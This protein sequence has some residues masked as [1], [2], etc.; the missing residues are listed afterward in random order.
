MSPEH[1]SVS[2]ESSISS[3]TG[4]SWRVTD[5]TV[6]NQ[7]T[8]SSCSGAKA[9]SEK[10]EYLKGAKTCSS[11]TLNNTLFSAVF[12]QLSVGVLLIDATTYQLVEVN[13]TLAAWL[14]YSKEKL[15]RLTFSSLTDLSQEQ[16]KEL[17]ETTIF[18]GQH[19]ESCL[20]FRC[21]DESC[22][23]LEGQ[24]Q[25]IVH[26]DQM[27]ICWLVNRI[28]QQNQ[29]VEETNAWQQLNKDHT[30]NVIALHQA[31][32]FQAAQK[33][34]EALEH[35]N[36]LKDNFLST[37]SHEL[38]TPIATI[39]MAIQ[40]LTLALGQE[41]LLHNPGKA[42]GNKTKIAHYLKILNDE[43]NR[44]IALITDL[45]DLQRLE[46]GTHSINVQLISLKPYLE[47]IVRPFQEQAQIHDQT[48]QL[49]IPETLPS[50]ISD[51]QS[52]ERIL[53]ELLTNACKYSPCGSRIVLKAFPAEDSTGLQTL[54]FRVC[55]SGVEIPPEQLSQIFDKF[56]RIPDGDPHRYSGTG[57]GLAL[58][59][60]LSLNLGG[61]VSAES[62]NGKT[63]FMI[64]IPQIFQRPKSPA[65][66]ATPV[67]L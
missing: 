53:V 26:D 56:Y 10:G 21:Q 32:L 28:T 52:L 27:L 66:A 18:Q 29:P 2:C 67:E 44:E 13:S 25:L 58:V 7:Q 40:M 63:C 45:L 37:I 41:G 47:R 60:K 17:I 9:S 14:G 8:L 24:S 11:P 16:V 43:C 55:N 57:L 3:K 49:E 39:K 34:V 48:L 23:T 61:K 6:S 38:R 36:Q 42:L 33:Q 22:I 35:I 20:I 54:V 12:N 15:L 1:S 50:V 65:S 46:A 62:G 59:R 51:I 31:K 5:P 64:E 30:V 4:H 19:R